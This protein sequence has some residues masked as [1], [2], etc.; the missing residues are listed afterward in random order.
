MSGRLGGLRLGLG[1]CFLVI[2]LYKVTILGF[3]TG[4]FLLEASEEYF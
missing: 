2:I 4:I 1:R 3:L